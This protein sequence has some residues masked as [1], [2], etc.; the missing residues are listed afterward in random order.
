[1][2]FHHH[3]RG[4]LA[5]GKQLVTEDLE[6]ILERFATTLRDW[7]WVPLRNLF[8]KW[9]GPFGSIM[10]LFAAV[11]HELETFLLRLKSA[12]QG[13]LIYI[14]QF[15]NPLLAWLLDFIRNPLDLIADWIV[16]SFEKWAEHVWDLAEDFIDR[17]W[18][19]ESHIRPGW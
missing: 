7:I 15:A 16:R 3:L 1:M 2:P 5:R 19:D 12:L 11:R 9:E 17:H 13:I 18:D 6:N 4:I 14:R 8:T 10:A